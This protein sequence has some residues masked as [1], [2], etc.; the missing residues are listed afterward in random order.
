MTQLQSN[1]AYLQHGVVAPAI[2]VDSASWWEAL[3]EHR[4]ELPR[5]NACRDF[6]FPPGPRCPVCGSDQVGLDSAPTGGQ[7]Y[8]WIVVHYPQD[9]AFTDDVPYTVVA[10]QLDAGPRLFGRLLYGAPTRDRRVVAQAYPVGE[11]TLLGFDA[12][13]AA[14]P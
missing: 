12:G 11:S 5:C 3:G 7:I 10:V 1:A 2:D 9:P 6:F 13:P 8:S 4:F 14:A